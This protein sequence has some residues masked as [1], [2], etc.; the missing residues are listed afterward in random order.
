M[1]DPFHELPSPDL[2]TVLLL[3]TRV[4]EEHS[5][6]SSIPTRWCEETKSEENWT[7]CAVACFDFFHHQIRLNC[8]LQVQSGHV[9]S[10]LPSCQLTIAI[11]YYYVFRKEG[12]ASVGG[13]RRGWTVARPLRKCHLPPPPQSL[14]FGGSYNSISNNRIPSHVLWLDVLMHFAIIGRLNWGSLQLQSFISVDGDRSDS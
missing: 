10:S 9:V 11:D 1:N 6:P 3:R 13:W 5:S 2:I 7:T 8:N 4:D 14:T 12:F